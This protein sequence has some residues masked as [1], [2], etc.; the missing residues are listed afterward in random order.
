M[1]TDTLKASCYGMLI[2]FLGSLPLGT[3]NIT[4]TSISIQ[5]GVQAGLFFALGSMT[6]ELVC[7][8]IALQMLNRLSQKVRL[9][10]AFKW[11]TVILLLVLAYSSFISA[12]EMKSFGNNIFSSSNIHPFLSGIL[13]SA[14]NPLHVPFWL[15]WSAILA[16][17]N[18]LTNTKQYYPYIIGI[19]T[20]T[21]PGFMVFIYGGPYIIEKLKNHQS[22]VNYAVGIVLLI[23][24]AI[25]AY[26]L[27]S[28]RL[29]TKEVIA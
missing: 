24:A 28:K 18:I 10:N 16:D 6:T 5:D 2:S 14:L 20:G 9:F 29:Q 22:A 1:K 11:M 17:R 26:K 21:I 3:L 23:T 19:G 27:V 15:G 13:L 4:A 7:V 25:E 8:R 12:A